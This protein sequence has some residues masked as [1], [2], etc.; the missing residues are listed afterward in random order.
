[1]ELRGLE[2]KTM[3]NIQLTIVGLGRMGANIA[4]RIKSNA[5]EPINICVFDVNPETVKALSDEGFVGLS[6]LNDLSKF[7][8]VANPQFVWVMVPAEVTQMTIHA[9]AE[10]LAPGSTIIDGGNTFYR[11]DIANAAWLKTKGIDFV[12]VGT[13]GGVF[14]L[15]RGYSLMIGGEA[16]VVDRLTPI[17]KAMAPGVDAAERTPGKV[18]IPSNSEQGFYHCGPVGSGHFIKMVHNGI[19]YGAMAAYAEGLNIIHAAADGIAHPTSVGDH[20]ETR[21][22]FNMEEVTEVW[23]RGSVVASWLLDLTATAYA[24][25]PEL[26]SYEG[27]VSDSGEGRWTV[28]TAIDAGVPANVLS[29]S[30]MGR[31]TSRGNDLY[32]NKVLSAMRKKFGGHLETKQQ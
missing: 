23:R 11:D 28:Q 13:S 8:D 29:A 16:G 22:D 2:E 26:A 6:S 4:R 25:D 10:H 1:M 14:G 24:E 15:A 20:V 3:T 19:E 18:G 27:S 21:Y 12:D 7:N 9:I 17:F 32:A 30:L 5:Q 31:F